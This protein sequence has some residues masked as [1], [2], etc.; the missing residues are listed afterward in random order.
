[1]T[2]RST[3]LPAAVLLVGSLFLLFFRL[4]H[5]ALWD[6]EAITAMTARA[7]WHTG[8]T[9]A[10]VDDHNLLVYRNGLLVRNFKDRYTPPLQFYLIAPFVGLIGESNFDCRLPIA[11]CGV[12]TVL[13]LMWWLSRAKVS[14]FTWWAAAVVLLTN[15]EFFLF[16]RQ[17]RY[18][19]LAMMLATAVAFFYC[20][21]DGRLRWLVG[22]SIA[23][24]ALLASQYLDY[25]A[26][27]ACLIVDYLIWGRK[28]PIGLRGWLIILLP[29]LVV[30]GIVC[31]IW[32]PLTHQAGPVYHPANWMFD[33]A[34]LLWW[35]WRDMISSDFVVMPLLLGC[36]LLYAF[37]KSNWLLRA[38]LALVVFVSAIAMAV[39]AALAQA[40]NAEIRYLAPAAPLCVGIG[41]VAI[42]GLQ[43]LPAPVKWGVLV[44]AFISTLVDPAAQGSAPV[45]HSTP[46]L[47]YHELAVPQVES[48]TPVMDWI[49]KHVPAG[50]SIYVQ[51]GF[52]MYPLMF[53]DSKAI[54]A[55]QLTDPPRADFK[56]LPDIHFFGRVPPDFMIRFG[57]NGESSD[58]ETAIALLK[59]RGID[60]QLVDTI[61][62]AW[63]DYYRPERVWHSFT[64]MPSTPGD[65]IYIWKRVR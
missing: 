12:V 2:S 65:E 41:I 60:Y 25:A 17:C 64:T 47:F 52:K 7:V 63:R 39:P 45:F 61:H 37:G 33:R 34:L 13:L 22:L 44:I 36:P 20:N 10:R 6:D 28:Q 48:Y 38:P 51:P 24:A 19:G 15:V 50:A 56:D 1:M 29:Q 16:F 46:L 58:F 59:K 21:R 43:S 30:G 55:W 53:R 8:D 32:N 11:L 31:S 18:Y 49:D 5:Y 54:Y 14:A 35:N 40:T 27:I 57:T 9:S 42:W 26:V 62:L 4:G 3:L 23:L